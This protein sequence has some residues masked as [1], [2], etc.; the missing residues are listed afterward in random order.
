MLRIILDKRKWRGL[1][2]A[3]SNL[4]GLQPIRGIYDIVDTSIDELGN[5]TTT[6]TSTSTQGHI[7]M[8]GGTTTV[9][10]H[11]GMD[12]VKYHYSAED[13]LDAYGVEEF[14]RVIRQRK[15][16]RI[17]NKDGAI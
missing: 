7:Y 5:V 12:D 14:E 10:S 11:V 8:N 15:L 9:R 13:L 1:E 4:N 17:M 3:F 6:V 2:M 16:N